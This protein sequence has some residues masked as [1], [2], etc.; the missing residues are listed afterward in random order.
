MSSRRRYVLAAL[1]VASLVAATLLLHEALGTVFLAVTVA[2]VLLPV[3]HRLA[4]RVSPRVAAALTT[5][6]AGVGVVAVSLP[7]FWV[8]YERRAALFD[9]LDALPDE[10]PVELFGFEYAVDVASVLAWAQSV[11]TDAAVATARAAPVLA[12]KLVLFAF[13]VYALLVRPGA[14]RSALLE[15]VPPGYREVALAFHRRARETLYAIYVLQAATAV[16]T[17]LA[18]LVVFAGLGYRSAFAFAVVCGVLQFVPVVG[19]SILVVALGAYDLA[20]GAPVRGVLVLALGLVVV[21]FL[22]DAVIRVKLA[23]RTAHLPGSVYFIGFT[24][25][26][27]SVGAV[28]FIAGPLAVALVMEAGRLLAE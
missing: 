21:A 19:P 22:P 27:L 6:L 17:F 18:A 7:L 12:L 14:V 9:L 1:F 11:A 5:A 8:L 24:G 4:G 20:F 2:A 28:G 15:L 10:V 16:G 13:L 25:G 26:V 3:R 23:D